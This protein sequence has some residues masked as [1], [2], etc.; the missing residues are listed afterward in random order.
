MPACSRT[1]WTCCAAPCAGGPH[2]WRR[3]RAPLRRRP[4]VRRRPPGLREPCAR[5]GGHAGDGGSTRR[6]PASRPLPRPG[7]RPR[8]GG[9]GR[10][11]RIGAGADRPRAAS[12]STLAPGT[13]HHLARVLERSGRA[14]HR[15]RRLPRRPPPRRPLPTSGPRPSAPMPGSR[16]RS[17]DG[18][19]HDRAQRVRSAQ[20]GRDGAASSRRAARSSP[21]RPPPATST[22]LSGRS[23][24]C[25]CPTTRRTGSTRSSPA[26]F[27]LAERRTIEH[28]CS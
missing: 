23:A 18:D 25:R 8:E 20:R 13:G 10:S 7:R 5:P 15:H 4:L 19:R 26:H 14:R 22:S 9:R 11:A 3:R 6:L 21:S 16:S 2:S 17:R 28:A 24:S 12:S 1:S 27:T